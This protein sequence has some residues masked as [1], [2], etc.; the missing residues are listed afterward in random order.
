VLK[1]LPP[2]ALPFVLGYA[3]EVLFAFMDKLVKSFV[4]EEKTV[5]PA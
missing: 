3:I 2:L 5:R 4:G 1:A